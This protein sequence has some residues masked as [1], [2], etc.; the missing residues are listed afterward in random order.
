MYID[1]YIYI[2]IYI[3]VL[4]WNFGI[5]IYNLYIHILNFIN[6]SKATS[7]WM[8]KYFSFCFLFLVQSIKYRVMLVETHNLKI[9]KKKTIKMVQRLTCYILR[10][11]KSFFKLHIF[12]NYLIIYKTVFIE[13][14]WTLHIASTFN[15]NLV[16]LIY[17]NNLITLDQFL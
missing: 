13:R 10:L 16:N 1:I 14:V 4:N 2:Y 11:S 5:Y 6:G 15:I 12:F 8:I 17:T 9:V 3:C 7:P